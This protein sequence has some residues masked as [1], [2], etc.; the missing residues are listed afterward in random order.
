MTDKDYDKMSGREILDSFGKLIPEYQYQ[1]ICDIRPK[2]LQKKFNN[3]STNCQDVWIFE[4]RIKE[5]EEKKLPYKV[6]KR[7]EWFE[8]NDEVKKC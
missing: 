7:I 4:G 1:R 5:L 6:F 8:P 3:C 2:R